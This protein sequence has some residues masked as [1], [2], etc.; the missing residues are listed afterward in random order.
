[1]SYEEAKEYIKQYEGRP[2]GEL[3]QAQTSIWWLAK[4]VVLDIEEAKEGG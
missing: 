3:T 1:V 4:G 2:I